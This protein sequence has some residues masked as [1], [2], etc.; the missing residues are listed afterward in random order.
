MVFVNAIHL[1][2]TEFKLNIVGVV[3]ELFILLKSE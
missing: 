2:L 1:Y 3:F